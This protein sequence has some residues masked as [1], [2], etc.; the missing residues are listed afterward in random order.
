ME[1]VII[2]MVPIESVTKETLGANEIM[3]DAFDVWLWS[4]TNVRST[5]LLTERWFGSRP[6]N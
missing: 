3:N 1:R 2:A 5:W 4:S 6:P